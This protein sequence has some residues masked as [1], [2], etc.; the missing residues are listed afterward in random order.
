MSDSTTKTVK[1]DI[2]ADSKKFRDELKAASADSNAFNKNLKDLRK[3]GIKEDKGLQKIQKD[4]FKLGKGSGKEALKHEKQLLSAMKERSKLLSQLQKQGKAESAQFKETRKQLAEMSNLYTDIKKA[5]VQTSGPS[6]RERAGS[7]AGRAGSWVAGKAKWGLLGI[8][9]AAV[10][11][12]ASRV[13]S[14]GDAASSFYRGGIGLAGDA[15]VGG[16]DQLRAHARLGTAAGYGPEDT[17]NQAIGVSRATGYG[18]DVNT[19]QQFSRVGMLDTG[20]A[21]GFMGLQARGGGNSN[22]EKSKKD[23]EK[24]LASAFSTGLERGR[25]GEFLEGVSSLTEG[26]QG[27]TSRDVDGTAYAGLLGNL[28]SSGLSGFKGQRGASVLSQLEQGFMGG[29]GQAGQAISLRAMGFGGPGGTTSYYDAMKK[30]QKGFSDPNNMSAY[31]KQLQ[32]E[33][34]GDGEAAALAGNKATGL[35]IQTMED[36]FKVVNKGGGNMNDKI[37]ELMKSE[38]SLEQQTLDVLKTDLADQSKL[39]SARQLMLVDQGAKI[40]DDLNSM[41]E[42]TNRMIDKFWPVAVKTLEII[43]KTL[44]VVA[45]GVTDAYD[46][47]TRD[48]E[49]ASTPGDRAIEDAEAF[50]K[51]GE[52]Q[53]RTGLMDEK[54][55]AAEVKRRRDELRDKSAIEKEA[56]TSTKYNLAAD[57]YSKADRRRIE[58]KGNDPFTQMRLKE[59]ADAQAERKRMEASRKEAEKMLA[60]DKASAPQQ[61]IVANADQVGEAAGHGVVKATK[62]KGQSAASIVK[63][64]GNLTQQGSR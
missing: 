32:N 50:I 11:A 7:A 53:V 57:E 20:A 40:L 25:F 3:A 19:M 8:G 39:Q 64:S 30:Q 26:A 18:N 42:A 58:S 17:M 36:L 28:Q 29:G 9:G 54:E 35:S 16:M 61:V 1:I 55:F 41:Q 4:A 31:V 62:Q 52:R 5:R 27:R 49:A 47:W 13:S 15:G 22:P 56:V 14:A 45:Q 24:I 43:A 23:L 44:D 2:I 37:A 21:T 38:A 51:Q 48:K 12:L 6:G 33:Y 63:S 60:K 34:G 10:G 59:E 46:F